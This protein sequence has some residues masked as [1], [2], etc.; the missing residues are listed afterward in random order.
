[1]AASRAEKLKKLLASSKKTSEQAQK[2]FL[3]AEDRLTAIE[4]R[5]SR[6]KERSA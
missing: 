1:M 4:D 3:K 5:E 6:R 2:A